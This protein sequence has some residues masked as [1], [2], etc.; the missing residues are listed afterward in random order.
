MREPNAN[1]LITPF[2]PSSVGWMML[3]RR[4]WLGAEPD[5]DLDLGRLKVSV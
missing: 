3:V 2:S 5:L 4:A 1:G